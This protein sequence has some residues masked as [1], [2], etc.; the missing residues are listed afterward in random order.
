MYTIKAKVEVK[1]GDKVVGTKEYDKVVFEGFSADDKGKPV[2]PSDPAEVGKL[3]TAARDFFKAEGGEK[4]TDVTALV[5]LLKNVTYAYDLGQRSSVRQ[6]I[7]NEQAGPEKSIEKAI[8]DVMA[9]RAQAGK[10]ITEEQARAKVLA[11]MA[12]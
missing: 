11:M 3:M 7:L 10:P 5:E 1:N 6:A 8:K 4:A 9:A 12:D 2:I